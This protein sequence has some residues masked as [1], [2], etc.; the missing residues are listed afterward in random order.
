MPLR[1][2]IDLPP[3]WLAGFA[4]LAWLLQDRFP[5]LA[6]GG[7]V[8]RFAGGLAFG[9]GILLMA[10]AASDMRRAR[11]TLMPH[12]IPDRMV[13]TGIFGRTRNPIYLGDLLL[14]TG[15]LLWWEALWLLPLVL[16]LGWLLTDRFIVEEEG[17]LRRKFRAD[18]ARY[19]R[20][21]PRWVPRHFR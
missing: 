11:T 6:F 17:F 8:A 2:W 14:L 5:D 4:A 10:L 15:L 13:T 12:E 1:K 19:E 16:L 7:G 3:V 9:G 21:V 18:F 20:R